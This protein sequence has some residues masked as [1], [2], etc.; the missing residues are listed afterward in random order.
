MIVSWINKV[1]D[2]WGIEV[3]LWS[4]GPGSSLFFCLFFDTGITLDVLLKSSDVLLRPPYSDRLQRV[5]LAG[6]LCGIFYR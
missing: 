4:Q 3:A 5:G 6:L 1:S 2:C